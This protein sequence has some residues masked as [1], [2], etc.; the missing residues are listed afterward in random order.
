MALYSRD[1]DYSA[2]GILL[3]G[4][5]IKE[6]LFYDIYYAKFEE[7]SASFRDVFNSRKEHL[8]GRESTPWAGVA[9]D[10]DLIA[11]RLKITPMDNNCG[12]IDLEPYIFYRLS[13]EKRL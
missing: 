2:A 7:K 10:S 11:A 13:D 6:K 8:I 5:L 4:E 1:T 3:S 12:K 9:K